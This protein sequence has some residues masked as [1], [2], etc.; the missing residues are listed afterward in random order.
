[1]AG[2][3]K[4]VRDKGEKYKVKTKNRGDEYGGKS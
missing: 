4:T 1:M 3:F 2:K